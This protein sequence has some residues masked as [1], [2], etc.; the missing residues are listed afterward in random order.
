MIFEYTWVDRILLPTYKI[1][2]TKNTVERAHKR[3]QHTAKGRYVSKRKFHSEF[4]LQQSVSLFSTSQNWGSKVLGEEAPLV[5]SLSNSL[6][7]KYGTFTSKCSVQIYGI[8]MELNVVQLQQS[9]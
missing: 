6:T 9:P 5:E 1:S 3:L 8:L 2:T 7:W 4:N